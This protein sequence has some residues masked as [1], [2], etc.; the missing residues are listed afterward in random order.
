MGNG[1]CIKRMA[2]VR[3]YSANTIM[4]KNKTRGK[5]GGGGG[6]VKDMKC[7]GV[8]L[9]GYSGIAHSVLISL[10]HF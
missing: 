2:A 6:R 10:G 9:K 8:L 4:E 5:A 1:A 3:N 7:S